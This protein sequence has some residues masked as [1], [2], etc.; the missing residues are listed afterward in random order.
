[1]TL[2]NISLP[3]AEGSSNSPTKKKHIAISL[4]SQLRDYIYSR[5]CFWLFYIA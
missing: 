1:L 2:V 5:L 4:S 3:P